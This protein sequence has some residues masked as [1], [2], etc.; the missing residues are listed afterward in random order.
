MFF[1]VWMQSI[2]QRQ[3]VIGEAIGQE[4]TEQNELLDKLDAEVDTTGAKL[5]KAKRT[6]VRLF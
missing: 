2:L 3:K 4:I 1:F 5:G 6:M